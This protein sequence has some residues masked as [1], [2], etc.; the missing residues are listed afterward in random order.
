MHNGS[1][2]SIP[3]RLGADHEFAALR[4]Y[5]NAADYT[6]QAICERLGL[7]KLS[8]FKFV[9]ELRPPPRTLTENPDSLDLLIRLFLENEPLDRNAVQF[10][11]LDLLTTL[12]L[13][14]PH[15]ANPGLLSGTVA[16]YPLRDLY[17]VSDRPSSIEGDERQAA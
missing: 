6:E 16:L 8:Q 1:P 12:G 2:P 11:P 15:T 10:L 14:V 17:I 9:T 3:L 5:F 13:I 7:Q 4:S